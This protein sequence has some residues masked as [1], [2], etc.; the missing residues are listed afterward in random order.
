MK[1]K[2]GE[3]KGKVIVEGGNLD[4]ELLPHE[5]TFP[6]EEKK[7]TGSVFKITP[8][9]TIAWGFV[10]ISNY[11]HWLVLVIPN[12]PVYG[13]FTDDYSPS[14]A[15]KGYYKL[16][17]NAHKEQLSNKPMNLL[18]YVE[19]F[20][21]DPGNGGGDKFDKWS[22][23]IAKHKGDVSVDGDK[24]NSKAPITGCIVQL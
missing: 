4:N 20:R 9:N 16:C 10:L 24:W 7:E 14:Q 1:H 21:P 3:Y 6:S 19:D 22:I 12:S 23:F 18:I 5:M 17:V 8:E 11:H 2:V 15:S 13:L